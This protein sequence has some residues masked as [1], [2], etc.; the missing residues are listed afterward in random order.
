[1]DAEG[2]NNHSGG[3][4]GLPGPAGLS[5]DVYRSAF[6]ASTDATLLSNAEGEILDANPAAC[7]LYGWS[8]EEFIGMRCTEFVAEDEQYLCECCQRSIAAG[9]PFSAE[10]SHVGRDG[11]P[12]A[13]E[14]RSV[15]VEIDGKTH[16][17]T[18]IRDVRPRRRREAELEQAA[19]QYETLY[20]SAHVG[21][22]RTTR[23]EGAFVDGNEP[24]AAMLGYE[25]TDQIV[26]RQVPWTHCVDQ[27]LFERVR[28]HLAAEGQ[29]A[30]WE[31]EYFRRDG[32]LAWARLWCRYL[33]SEDLIEG[34]VSDMTDEKLATEA[35]RRE[36]DFAAKLIDTAHAMVVVLGRT[37]RILRFNRFAR[38]LTGYEDK[39]VLGKDWFEMMIPGEDRASCRHAL[40]E[41]MDRGPAGGMEQRVVARSGR[42]VLVR[43]FASALR[44]I[45]GKALGMLV[46]GHD[47]TDI[48]QKEERLRQVSKMEAIGRLAG[49]IAHD[50]N[51][52][53]TIIKGYCDLLVR[54]EQAREETRKAAG[55]IQQAATQASV[56]T[57]ELLV[58]SRRH[59][60]HPRVADINRML[61]DLAEP[62]K[63][64]AGEDV[65]VRFTPGADLGA[66]RV[67][68]VQFE[69]AMIN[70]VAN[71]CEAM[72]DGGTIELRTLN[73]RVS[74]AEA[75][76][77][78]DAEE[79][80]YVMISVRDSGVGIDPESLERVFEPFYST[81]P[82]GKRAG[83]GLASVYGF[84]RQSGGYILVFSE[85]EEGTAFEIYLPHVDER[86]LSR[87]W[88][89]Q[90]RNEPGTSEEPR[91]LI[92]VVEDAEAVRRIVCRILSDAGYEVVEA[93]S[94]AEA[95]PLARELKDRIDLIVSD[96]VMPG[97]SGVE[98]VQGLRDDLPDIE[99]LYISGY[100]GDAITRRG[101]DDALENLLNKPFDP[102]ELLEM[103]DRLLRRRSSTDPS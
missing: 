84:V 67:D 48:R 19:R 89:G 41:I 53:L 49:G 33:E 100:T 87:E 16:V 25:S 9:E 96:V 62:L 94:A 99:V 51:N 10:M 46:I 45:D 14:G 32:S 82:K 4:G 63:R 75:Q 65:E 21:H 23:D 1:M 70:L 52:Q 68:P 58:F 86:E 98:L 24:L 57:R 60:L 72:P 47:V 80:D 71:A 5:D 95:E 18:T 2:T 34:I 3:R 39:D 101:L 31:V 69:Q 36:R 74:A 44:D 97:A 20:D 83:M 50:F 12:L 17:L 88:M 6:E 29:V 35:L 22:F 61:A 77:F 102:A 43:F 8:R 26:H 91:P 93:S 54:D 92:L 66:V 76:A 38:E 90:L 28:E 85:P 11:R 27:G 78:P 30:G 7:E 81:K 56:L 73:Q 59:A 15:P 40:L 42:D 64:M 79:G 103:V 37:G 13:V 55:E